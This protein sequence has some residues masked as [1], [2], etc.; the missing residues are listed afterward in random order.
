MKKYKLAKKSRSKKPYVFPNYIESLDFIK[1]L[2]LA[3]DEY[4]SKVPVGEKTIKVY[5]NSI[6]TLYVEGLGNAENENRIIVNQKAIDRFHPNNIDNKDFWVQCRK[7]FPKLSVCGQPSKT[8]D[9]VNNNTFTIPE[10]LGFIKFIDEQIENSKE[11]INLLE[12]G[13]G[14]GN[15]FFKYKDRCNYFGIDYIIPRN[16]K[17]Y[18]NFIEI[19]KSGIPD[20]LL[21]EN[22]FDIIYAVNVLQHCSQRDRFNYFRQGYH[23]LKKGGYFIFT[24]N[25]MTV[26]NKDENFWGIVDEN[27]RGY[28]GF[29]NQLTEC[30][31]DY[32]LYAVLDTLGFKP[33]SG[34]ITGNLLNLIIKKI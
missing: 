6:T 18:K 7:R 23:A 13:F 2:S 27:D 26:Q 29:F 4:A 30:D 24:A 21:N 19:D 17:K 11:K 34:G 15:M 3:K 22:L 31:W 28:T 25:I 14:Y 20:Y 10:R 33:V 8:I 9:D 5:T 12:I 1:S 16:L 32:E